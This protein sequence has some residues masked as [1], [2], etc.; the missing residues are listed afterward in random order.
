MTIIKNWDGTPFTLEELEELTN[1]CD[2][3]MQSFD[4]LAG[5]GDLATTPSIIRCLINRI[6]EL[7]TKKKGNK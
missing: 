4:E 1:A 2:E 5:C 6:K 3:G 7:E